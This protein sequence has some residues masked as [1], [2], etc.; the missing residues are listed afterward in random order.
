MMAEPEP[1]E[2]RR[3]EDGR[4]CCRWKGTRLK[5][6]RRKKYCRI[7]SQLWHRWPP[8]KVSNCPFPEACRLEVWIHRVGTCGVGCWPC[9][10][11]ADSL[12]VTMIN[13]SESYSSFGTRFYAEK[14]CLG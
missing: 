13:L 5:Q 11:P 14:S 12:Q 10:C 6:V 7:G 1:E 8:G 9:V 3:K 4:K 2:R